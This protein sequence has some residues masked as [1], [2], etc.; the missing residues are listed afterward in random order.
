MPKPRKLH[1]GYVCLSLWVDTSAMEQHQLDALVTDV[2]AAV[3]R[4]TPAA[5]VEIPLGLMVD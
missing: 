5:H 1:D 4:Y 3:E 2:L